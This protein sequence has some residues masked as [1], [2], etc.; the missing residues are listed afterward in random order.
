[1]NKTIEYNGLTLK[2]K[3]WCEISDEEY[4]FL[5]EQYYKKPD[6]ID[7]INEIKKIDIGG[8]KNSYITKYYFKDLMAKTKLYHSKWSI[9]DVWN[10]KDLVASFVART[11]TNEKVYPVNKSL[12]ENIETA[13]R[14]GGKGLA[15]KP[16]NFPV[17]VSDYIIKKYNINNNWYDF[18]C[19]WG[20][21]L[22]SGMKQR[23]N[24]YG[25]DP[26]N[27]LTER[28][29][30][31]S[32]LYKET[33][34]TCKTI[35]DIKAQG[36]EFFIP[37]YKNKIGLAF[38][39]PPY[40]N[41]EDYKIGK[42]SYKEGVTYDMWISEYLK[43]TLSNIYLYL[44]KNGKLAININNFSKYDLIRDVR[45]IANVLGYNFE[46][47]ETLENIKR[48]NMHGELNNNSEGII[49]FTK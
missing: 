24:Y 30:D 7:V 43:P 27:I 16:S 32:N 14:I 36:S 46:C 21:R 9:E 41:L 3:H 20:S 5:K 42:Q 48:C 37:E 19:G 35:I 10:C 6:I 17:K 31:Y 25:T 49:I 47:V 8:V 13:M 15:G 34:P 40:F 39:S 29:V 28:L 4:L 22:T 1:M 33:I 11:K 26:N 23:I 45:Q 12:I 18:S 38:S 2:T 44:I